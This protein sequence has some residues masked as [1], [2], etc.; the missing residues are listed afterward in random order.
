MAVTFNFQNKTSLATKCPA[1]A[2]VGFILVHF[3]GTGIA[4]SLRVSNA[5]TDVRPQ[6]VFNPALIRLGFLCPRSLVS[7]RIEYT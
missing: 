2:L 5:L 1:L 7:A 4:C 6:D 3:Y